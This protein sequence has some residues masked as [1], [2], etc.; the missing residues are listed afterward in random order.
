MN[1][2][3]IFVGLAALIALQVSP[4]FAQMEFHY[5]RGQ[6]LNP[7]TGNHHST[8]ILTFQQAGSWVLGRSFFF[9]DFIDDVEND[10]FNDR[11]FY[12]EW[13]PSLSLSKLFGRDIKLGPIVDISAVAGLN[14]DGDVNLLKF[15]PG[16]QFSWQVPGFVFVN[17][18]FAA[19]GDYSDG[20][21]HQTGF[22]FDVSW[23]KIMNFGGQTFSFMG[24]AEYISAVDGSDGNQ[25]SEA[26]ILAQPQLVWDAGSLFQT[27]NWLHVGIELQY[28]S[29]KLGVM[30]QNE[31]RPQLLVV[32]RLQ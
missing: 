1:R 11:D 8:D 23:L 3:K 7:F 29:N 15:L 32:W 9:I 12:G 20:T 13:Y 31:L 21:R 5:Q 4:V 25:V 24:H 2:I 18:D 27:P 26:W 28:W 22:M 16:V 6:L 19:I 14:F 30:D 10:G 17:T